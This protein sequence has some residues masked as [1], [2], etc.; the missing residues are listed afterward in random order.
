MEYSFVWKILVIT[1]SIVFVLWNRINRYIKFIR[2]KEISKRGHSVKGRVEKVFFIPFGSSMTRRYYYKPE[3]SYFLRGFRYCVK[4]LNTVPYRKYVEGVEIE[5]LYLSEHPQ[6]VLVKDEKLNSGI[7]LLWD[8][9][10][11]VFCLVGMIIGVVH[12]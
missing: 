3:V 5:L 12:M 1:I 4:T 8:T 11:L 9:L 6:E 10:M 2:E 7:G